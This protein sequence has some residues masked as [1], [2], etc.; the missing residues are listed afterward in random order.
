MELLTPSRFQQPQQAAGQPTGFMKWLPLV[1][2]SLA[3]TIIILDTTILNVAFKTIIHDLNANVQ[4]IQWVITAY[5]LMLAAFTIT[6]GRLGDYFGRKKM[7]VLGAVIFAVGSFI[8]SISNSVGM[9]ILGEA[10]IEGIGACL[11]L[12][13]T[14]SLLV[15]HY[16]GRDRQVAFGVWGGL[17]AAAAAFGPIVGGFLTTYYSWRWAFRI[18]LFVAVILAVGSIFI[19]ESKVREDSAKIDYLGIVLSA[20]GL[21][22]VVFGVIESSTYGWWNLKQSFIVFGHSVSGLGTISATPFFIVL[23]IDI[24]AIFFLWESYLQEQG[25]T[26]LVSFSLFKNKQFTLA[27]LITSILALVQTGVFFALP[28]FLQ[29]VKNL[30]ALHTGYALLPMTI[31]LLVASPLSAYFS[32]Y[33]TPKLIIQAGLVLNIVGF[34]LLIYEL[35]AT[36]SV[37]TLAPGFIV[38]GIGMGFMFSQTSNMALSAVP[39][40]NSGEAS[41]VNTTMRQLGATLG[42]AI[43]GAILLSAL[44]QSIATGVQNSS[45]I[46]DQQKPV[47][48]QQLSMQTNSIA[49]EG[50]SQQSSAGVPQNI[51]AEITRIINQATVDGNREALWY[52]I[53]FVI[54]GLLLSF[55]LPNAIDIETGKKSTA[56]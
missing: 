13:A 11:M 45:V 14:V 41:G 9:M 54:L 1:I 38:I 20:L 10:I 22:S 53:G 46:P 51:S 19:H 26:P 18:N 55:G 42:A 29:G 28:V 24:L 52:G 40:Q 17:A 5:S 6:G 30:D 56:A 12:P 25:K 27:A 2:L 49:I 39:V 4:Q 3:L 35:S 48:A 8:T 34:V 15:A 31:A 7:F 21:L 50:S 47:I 36:A 32:K 44:S 37:W 23:G 43:M 33:I 16:Q